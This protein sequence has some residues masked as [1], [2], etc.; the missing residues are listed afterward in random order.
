MS[1]HAQVQVG[2]A[3]AGAPGGPSTFN[4]FVAAAT[5]HSSAEAKALHKMGRKAFGAPLQ[6]G[7]PPLIVSLASIALSRGP[8]GG[9]RPTPCLMA[10]PSTSPC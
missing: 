4:S 8:P 5:A 10:P 3:K 6:V 2:G 1:L 9:G 7:G